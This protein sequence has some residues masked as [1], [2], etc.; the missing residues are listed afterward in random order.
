MSD[1]NPPRS[2]Q[3]ERRLHAALDQHRAGYPKA[4][5]KRLERLARHH[6]NEPWVYRYQAA[7]L[8]DC[9]RLEAARAALEQAIGLS[10][11]DPQL[12]IER[13]H[14]FP[15]WKQ[16]L[17]AL[18]NGASRYAG[19]RALGLAQANALMHL[20]HFDEALAR[21]DALLPDDPEPATLYER[22]A[23]CCR[24]RAETALAADVEGEV[25]DP[26]SDHPA[27]VWL[28]AAVGDYTRAIAAAPDGPGLY[29]ARA[30][31][32]RRLG[33]WLEAEAD[34][35]AAARADGPSQASGATR[36]AAHN[37]T[38]R[39]R[40]E[41]LLDD[42]QQV[43]APHPADTPAP[44]PARGATDADCLADDPTRPQAQALA[45]EIY[46]LAHQPPIELRSAHP[47]DVPR[48]A[49]RFV[50]RVA[51]RLEPLGFEALGDF[52][53][54]PP[55]SKRA[56]STLVRL[57]LSPDETVNVSAFRLWPAHRGRWWLIGLMGLFGPLRSRGL[58]EMQSVLTDGRYVV[59]RNAGRLDPFGSGG[60]VRINDLPARTPAERVYEYHLE[61]LA[62]IRHDTG[63]QPH[64]F[65]GLADILATHDAVRIRLNQY[66]QQIGYVTE[67]ELR[68]LL[69]PDYGDLGG[70]VR[71]AIEQLSRDHP[72]SDGPESPGKPD[73]EATATAERPGTVTPATALPATETGAHTRSAPVGPT[74][75]TSDDS[76]L[77]SASG[78]A[79]TAKR[80]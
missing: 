38:A 50:T 2:R 25:T 70:P 73:D 62:Q 20:H 78:S 3:Y 6:P 36:P 11:D 9:D 18:A 40:R 26:A 37:D 39:A 57:F 23:V 17:V 54:H 45:H 7:A 59:T 21:I 5:L 31:C 27:R 30:E 13:A 35:A 47:E 72:P 71:R 10:P 14:C 29:R 63:H 68:Q 51:E 69:G 16:T 77:Y 49:R 46:A 34:E 67:A 64:R 66:R 60:A 52:E 8:R 33:Q 22:R 19:S 42:L 1:S 12:W 74:A 56:R 76:R 61:V 41:A 28:E 53:S 4:A 43:L 32:W 44:E 65:E 80:M 79:S 15:S 24:Q 55:R 75:R 48:T 58:V